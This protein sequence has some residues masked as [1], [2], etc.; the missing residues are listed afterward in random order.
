LNILILSSV[1]SDLKSHGQY[2]M[3]ANSGIAASTSLLSLFSSTGDL[4]GTRFIKI[5]ISEEQLVHNK[6]IPVAGTLLDDLIQLSGN[7]ILEDDV[8][9]YL[10]VRMDV[11]DE[12]LVVFYVP[13][14]ARVRDKVGVQRTCAS[15]SI[16]RL[17]VIRVYAFIPSQGAP[18]LCTIY[19]VCYLKG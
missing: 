13:E 15:R 2:L 8:P 18:I 10:L 7:E 3:S 12:W 1:S 16:I 19:P 4:T 14:T 6:S 17:D 5:S 9:A 11:E